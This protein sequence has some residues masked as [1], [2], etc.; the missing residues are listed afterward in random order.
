[1]SKIAI[2]TGASRLEGIGAEICRE[3]ADAGY[4]IFFTYWMPYDREMPWNVD[5]EEPLK[6]KNE[7][8]KELK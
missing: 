2:V 1:M 5:Q 6:L 7:L 8:L 3:L 4:H